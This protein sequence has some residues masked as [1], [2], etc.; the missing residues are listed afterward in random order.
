MYTQI[1]GAT[2]KSNKLLATLQNALNIL[3]KFFLK[4]MCIPKSYFILI[5]IF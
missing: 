1:Q 4:G 5:V 3:I 2:E